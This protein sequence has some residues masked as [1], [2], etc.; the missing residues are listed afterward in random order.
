MAR[1]IDI[2]E[3]ETCPR[4]YGTG[5]YSYTSMYGRTC[6][7]CHGAKVVFTKR[8]QAAYSYLES[9]L[10]IPATDAVVGG[11]YRLSSASKRFTVNSISRDP[12]GIKKSVNGEWVDVM[13]I[14]LETPNSRIVIPEGLIISRLPTDDD[15]ARVAAFQECLT[16]AGKVAKKHQA[17]YADDEAAQK[18]F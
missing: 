12:S 11:R 8:G 4:C 13:C 15:L 18:L 1:V 9:I 5:E 16:K 3:H 2:L 17:K 6:F 7:K 14:V 10:E